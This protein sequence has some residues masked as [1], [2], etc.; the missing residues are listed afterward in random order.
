[1]R[2]PALDEPAF[3]FSDTFGPFDAQLV[4][5]VA[6]RDVPDDPVGDE[7]EQAI[8]GFIDAG[9]REAQ[10]C[11]AFALVD[12]GAFD[13]ADNRA[14]RPL[15]MAVEH[16]RVRLEAREIDR[17]A[18]DHED[19]L[20]IDRRI[21]ASPATAAH[22]RSGGPDDFDGSG[23]GLDRGD[24]CK[25]GLHRQRVPHRRRAARRRLSRFHGVLEV[26]QSPGL[27][28]GL[29]GSSVS[30]ASL[31]GS[32]GSGCAVPALVIMRGSLSSTIFSRSSTAFISAISPSCEA[33]S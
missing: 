22:G 21:N 8:G 30:A 32:F 14:R 27:G 5:A 19:F 6:D 29:P 4:D 20:V 31:A 15:R 11:P 12:P 13:D 3:R 10:A 23:L 28:F 24:R 16:R 25:P 18:R 17:I 26:D 1:M 7:R 33:G 2:R 9:L